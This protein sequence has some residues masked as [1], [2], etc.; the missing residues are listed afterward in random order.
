MQP[1]TVLPHW[2]PCDR[3]K[4]LKL[5]AVFRSNINK[6]LKQRQKGPTPRQVSVRANQSGGNRNHFMVKVLALATLLERLGVDA[7]DPHD[8][9]ICVAGADALVRM[10]PCRKRLIQEDA[11]RSLD[12]IIL[13]AGPA[14]LACAASMRAAG[15]E[16]AV[17]EKADSVGSVWRRHYDRLHLHTDRDHS[18]LPGMP[19][20]QTYPLYPSR[21]EVI[22]YFENYATQFEIRPVFNTAVTSIRRNDKGWQADTAQGTITA[23]LVIVA[24]GIAGAPYRPSWPGS[25]LYRGTVVHSSEYEN[26]AP[27]LGK[28]VLVVGFG[29][30]GGEIALDLS[31]AD[32]DVALAVRGPVQILPRDLLGLPIMSWAIFYEHFPARLVD[33]INAPILRLVLGSFE[34]M[35]L[36]RAAKGPRRMIDEDGR[37]PLI[38]IGTLDKIREGAIK[39]RGGIDRLTPDGVV[40]D[41]GKAEQFDA[42]ILA[43]GFRPDLRALVPGEQGVFDAHGMPLQTGR[44]TKA[45]GLYF[46]GQTTSATGQLREIGR[47]ARRIA[48]A[49][50]RYMA[51]LRTGA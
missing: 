49:S 6:M 18:G 48:D 32:V 28:R 7:C 51:G 20:P 50:K 43:T 27:Y 16:A 13:G 25:E 21:D 24:T 36:R 5:P 11:L 31:D 10:H 44:P 47:E 46:C 42:I 29:N 2:T 38:D 1:G 3:K 12:A 34:K 30:S 37:I 35:G 41:G 33:F 4:T 14:G 22:A 39:I 15:F 19:M 26:P 17:F 45:P 23:P 9:A 40:F 8:G